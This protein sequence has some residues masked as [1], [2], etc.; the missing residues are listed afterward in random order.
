MFKSKANPFTTLYVVFGYIIVFSIWWGYLLY[1]KN[2]TAYQETIDLNDISYMIMHPGKDYHDTQEFEKITRKYV[3]QKI[4]IITE[5]SVFMALLVFGLFRVHRVFTKE[6]ELA[7]QQRNFLLSITHELKSPLSTIKI[8]L[9]TLLKRKLDEDKT[10]RLL[11]NSLS[12]L[13]RLESLVDNILFAAKIERDEP[14]FST[15]E[16]NTSDI[17]RLV[18]DRFRLNKKGIQITTDIEDEVCAHLDALGFTSV[19]INLV[20][21]AIKYSEENSNVKVALNKEGDS[22]LLRIADEGVGIDAAERWKIFEKFYR[23]GSEDTRKTKGTGLGLYIV[24]RYVEIYKGTIDV[25]PNTPK[26][27]IFTISLPQ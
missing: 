16:I 21:N 5:G 15:E 22:I 25:T 19:V 26:G 17:V 13:D 2:E 9:Q 27:S 18:T 14:G 12:D 3:R 6:M 1:Q 4:M 24:K 20:E 10:N 23:V 8:S 11:N 7:E